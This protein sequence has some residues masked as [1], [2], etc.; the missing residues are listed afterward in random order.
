ML[1]GFILLLIIFFILLL[2]FFVFQ[3]CYLIFIFNVQSASLIISLFVLLNKQFLKSIN[4]IYYLVIYLAWSNLNFLLSNQVS[5]ILQVFIY[6]IQILKQF[7]LMYNLKPEFLLQ[8]QTCYILLTIH[9]P[10]NLFKK[11]FVTP[12]TLVT[13]FIYRVFNVFCQSFGSVLLS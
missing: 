6:K 3:L 7:F 1:L 10:T 2:P 4:N 11:I 9:L 5:I 12:N 8:K 13:F